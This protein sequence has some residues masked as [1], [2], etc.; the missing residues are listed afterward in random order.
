MIFYVKYVTIDHVT[1]HV[2]PLT[3]V[4][5]SRSPGHVTYQQQ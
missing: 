1:C 2:W 3:K 5:R 4:E